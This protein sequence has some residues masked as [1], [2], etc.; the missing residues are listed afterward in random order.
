MGRAGGGLERQPGVGLGRS[1]GRSVVVMFVC[2]PVMFPGTTRA[3]TPQAQAD[4]TAHLRGWVVLEG[5][6]TPLQGAFVYLQGT[7]YATRTD[8]L[9]RFDLGQ[10]PPGAHQVTLHHP[11]WQIRQMDPPSAIF[12]IS[13]G[14]TTD[15]E[16]LVPSPDHTGSEMDPFPL[17][18]ITATVYADI[19]HRRAEG[20]SMRYIGS[21]EIARY[22][23]TGRSVADLVRDRIASL[24][25]MPTRNG[26]GMECIQTRRMGEDGLQILHQ[27]VN[28]APDCPDQV[29]VIVDGVKI[30]DPST[31]L[32]SLS[33]DVVQSVEFVP[34]S[35]AGARYGTGFA[36][37]VLVIE[38]REG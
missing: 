11:L 1:L 14:E 23:G 35:V 16:W 32:P 36:G 28:P 20:S 19:R 25:A 34:A 17:D 24:R 31:Y 37:G 8:T 27:R 3:Q 38:T 4:T 22:R 18:A 9:G 30:L 10:V 5:T 15:L 7:G 26:F 12:S 2:F 33:L 21:E 6:R 29:A 13:T